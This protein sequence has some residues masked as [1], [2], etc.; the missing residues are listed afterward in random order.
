MMAWG[1]ED[2]KSVALTTH[3]IP[4]GF[5]VFYPAHPYDRSAGQQR[6][7]R[8]GHGNRAFRW[9]AWRGDLETGS[10]AAGGQ[11]VDHYV[12]AMAPSV[13]FWR[14]LWMRP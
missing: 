9:V 3:R 7:A 10:V 8:A 5:A 12:G 1:R 14:L 6:C 2:A 13:I 11:V 4:V